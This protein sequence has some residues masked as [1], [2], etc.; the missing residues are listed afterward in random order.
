[1]RL[2]SLSFRN[3]AVGDSPLSLSPVFFN[4]IC[5]MEKKWTSTLT[6]GFTLIELMIVVGIIG[7]LAA[8]A[9]PSFYKARTRSQQNACMSNLKQIDGAAQQWALEFHKTSS[10]TY[11]LASITEFLKGSIIPVCPA[12]G[13]YNPGATV[14]D[15][16]TCDIA[17]HTL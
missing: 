14:G 3:P 5:L 16:P 13:N 15:N 2:A 6:R 8:I 11:T 17:G 4:P 7:L 1:M 10:D 12:G 9:I